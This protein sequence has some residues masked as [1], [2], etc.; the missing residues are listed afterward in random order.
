MSSSAVML[1]PVKELLGMNFFIPD[2]QRGYRWKEQQAED[3][4][5]DIWSFAEDDKKS[6]AEIYCIQPLVV[7]RKDQKILEKIHNAKTVEEVEKLIKGAWNVVDG[8]QRLTTIFLILSVLEMQDLYEIEY[9]TRKGSKDFLKNITE[10][11]KDENIDFFHMYLVH[12]TIKKWF[13]NNV[14]D[15]EKFKETLLEKVNFIWYQISSEEEDFNHK[16]AIAAFTRLNIGKI[17]LTDAELIKALFLNRS[18]FSCSS[19]ELDKKQRE[20]AMEWD[21]IE[22]SLQ[23]DEFWLFLHGL[24]YSKPTRI[25][26]IFDMICLNDEYHI[27]YNERDGSKAQRENSKRKNEAIRKQIGDDEHKTFRYFYYAFNAEDLTAEFIDQK[28]SKIREYYQIFSEWYN[29]YKLY[30]YIG[31]LTTVFEDS[32]LVDELVDDWRNSSKREFV[33]KIE[34]RIFDVLSKS[35]GF[36]DLDN[37]I[38][39]E[40]YNDKTTSKRDC[41][42]VLLL[43]NIETIIQQNDK[44]VNDKQY[45]LPNFSKFPFHLYKKEK[46]DV[47]HIR[48]NAGDKINSDEAK[49]VFAMLSKKYIGDKANLANEIDKFLNGDL[50]FEDIFD[51]ILQIDNSLSDSDK[52]KIWNYALLDEATNKEYGN[53]IFP[54][55][56]AFVANKERGYKIKYKMSTDGEIDMSQRVE[57]IAFVPPCTRNVFA[58]FYTDIPDGMLEWTKTDAEAYLA[59]I[60]EKLKKYLVFMEVDNHG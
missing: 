26:F 3:L 59:D 33:K 29:D 48:P 60:K 37:F 30:H 18:N 58:K 42:P 45:A 27:Y 40:E 32:N 24:E 56:R 38:Y 31:Y 21:K 7:Q 12:D 2:Y 20:I 41:V 52:N 55:K 6:P 25:D 28:W 10:K 50:Q 15:K 34:K 36:F 4:L 49:K 16:S 57:E 53:V 9:Q 46:W 19:V 17:P 51:K 1:K 39:E 23:G 13:K 44:L 35:K 5:N 8:Q 43:H 54:I 11:D 22:Y 47:E 14:V